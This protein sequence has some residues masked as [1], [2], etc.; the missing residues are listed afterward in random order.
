VVSGWALDNASVP[1]SAIAS[2]V[3]KVDGI[4]AGSAAYGILRADV[5]AAYPGRPGCPNVGFS[6]FLDTTK[7]QAGPHT[8]TVS[9]T[10]SDG[11]PDT[12]SAS[13]TIIVP[14]SPPTVAIESPA[15]GAVLSGVVNVSGWAL[16]NAASIGTAISSVV[17]KLDG[18][19]LGNATYGIS[20]TDICTTFP[21]RPGCPNVGFSYLLDTAKLTPGSHTLTVIATDTDSTPTSGSVSVAFQVAVP[22]SVHIDSPSTNAT[23]SGT[24]TVSGWAIDNTATIGSVQV[25]VDGTAVGTAT[26][27]IQRTDVCAVFSGRPGCPNVGFTYQLNTAL[28]SPG[29]HIITVVATDTDAVP[30]KASYSVMVTVIGGG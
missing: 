28:L 30:D 4:V 8:I 22:P 26:Y 11:T 9:A 1:G 17:V 19:V 3:V 20:R 12:G 16:D 10:D 2:V 7:L 25:Q 14:V 29:T 24:V 21:G 6:Y 5:C 13:V 18:A 15:A 23:V 27:G